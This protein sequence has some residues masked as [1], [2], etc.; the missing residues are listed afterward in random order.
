MPYRTKV[1]AVYLLGF[2]VDLINMFIANVAYPAL[3][4]DLQASV[5]ELSWVS[6]GYILGLTLVI[7]LSAW[8]AQRIGERQVLLLSLG[9][10]LLATLGELFD[11]KADHRLGQS[12]DCRRCSE[13]AIFNYGGKD[14]Q[15][16]QI[17]HR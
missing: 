10:F 12:K 16:L 13:T 17:K 2:F 11:I 8:L 15:A 1:S 4:E 6:N 14:L 9:L 7:P 5:S 3:A